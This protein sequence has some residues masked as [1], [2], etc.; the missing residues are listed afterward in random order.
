MDKNAPRSAF[1]SSSLSPASPPAPNGSSSAAAKSGVSGSGSATGAAAQP[2][3]SPEENH[4]HITK[5]QGLRRTTLRTLR[6][7]LCCAIF[8]VFY[9]V[10]WAWFPSHFYRFRYLTVPLVHAE[11]VYITDNQQRKT[12]CRVELLREVADYEVAAGERDQSQSAEMAADDIPLHSRML[13]FRNRRFLLNPEA[14]E[15]ELLRPPATVPQGALLSAAAGAGLSLEDFGARAA[16]Y[17]RNLMCIPIPSIPAVMVAEV[18]SPFFVFQVYSV[19]LWCFE[20][21]WVFAAVI[22]FMA[23]CSL[24]MTVY[25]T[26]SSMVALRELAKS[27]CALTVIRGGRRMLVAST[28]LVIG[29]VAVLSEAIDVPCDLA[30]LTGSVVVNEAM[31]TGESVPVVKTPIVDPAATLSAAAAA[32]AISVGK[33]SRTTLFAGSRIMQIKPPRGSAAMLA[34]I[35]RSAT[36]TSFGLSLPEHLLQSSSGADVAGASGSAGDSMAALTGGLGPSSASLLQEQSPAKKAN[37]RSPL[38][39]A[40]VDADDLMMSGGAGNGRSGSFDPYSYDPPTT[41]PALAAAGAFGGA[42]DFDPAAAAAAAAAARLMTDASSSSSTTVRASSH[43]DDSTAAG[44][45][46]LAYVVHTGFAT[47]KGNMLSS[48]LFPPKS[49]FEFEAQA[50]K[51]LGFLF[52][53]A[54]VGFGLT[55]WRYH[56][57]GSPISVMVLRALDLATIVVPPS[58]PLAMSIGISFSIVSLKAYR[59]FCIAPS[60]INLSGQI[61]LMCFDKTGTLTTDSLRFRGVHAFV[62]LAP[63]TLADA[64]AVE[65]V[66]AAVATALGT[67]PTVA[68]RRALATISTRASA[69]PNAAAT[70]AAAAAAFSPEAGLFSP[71]QQLGAA[72]D[73]LGALPDGLLSPDSTRS[74]EAPADGGNGAVSVFS[75]VPAKLPPVVRAC[76]ATCHSLTIHEGAFIGDPLEIEGFGACQADFADAAAKGVLFHAHLKR[77]SNTA[78]GKK[79]DRIRRRLR[80]EAQLPQLGFGRT[81]SS[82]FGQADHSAHSGGDSYDDGDDDTARRTP[83]RRDGEDAFGDDDDVED[84]YEEP[85]D[86]ADPATGAATEAGS[87]LSALGSTRERSSSSAPFAGGRRHGAA[88]AS[89]ECDCHYYGVPIA[90]DPSAPSIAPALAAEVFCACDC[91]KETV[92]VASAYADS[93]RRRRGAAAASGSS[94]VGLG[95]IRDHSHSHAHGHHHHGGA[96]A[97]LA[98]GQFVKVPTVAAATAL[99]PAPPALTQLTAALTAAGMPPRPA[100]TSLVPD[101]QSLTERK[102]AYVT[103][104]ASASISGKKSSANSSSETSLSSSATS[105]SSSAAA[106]WASGARGAPRGTGAEGRSWSV[107]RQFPFESGLQRMGVLALNEYD[108]TLFSFVKGAPEMVAKL[109][110]PATV[111][112]SYAATV[113]WYTNEGHRVIALAA[114]PVSLGE[115]DPEASFAQQAATQSAGSAA[116][117]D[118]T[119]AAAAAS[120]L[121]D[122]RLDPASDATE[123]L[124]H[125]SRLLHGAAPL[126][127]TADGAV[128]AVTE[129]LAKRDATEVRGFAESGLT[130]LGL[131]VMENALKPATIPTLAALRRAAVRCVMVTGDNVKTAVSISKECGI[132][133]PDAAVFVSQVPKGVARPT[134]RDIRWVHSHSPGISLDPTTFRVVVAPPGLAGGKLPFQRFE[135]AVTGDAYALL[136]ID[137][138]AAIEA[139]A[140]RIDDAQDSGHNHLIPNSLSMGGSHTPPLARNPDGVRPAFAATPA[141]SAVGQGGSPLSPDAN[142]GSAYSGEIPLAGAGE[143][144]G[145]HLGLRDPENY[146]VA[147]AGFE[148]PALRDPHKATL[149]QRVILAGA[150]FSRM[151]PDQKAG[152]VSHYMALGMYTGMCGDGANDCGALKTAHMGVS[153]AES[154]ASIAAPFTSQISDIS[155]IPIVLCQGRSALATA[156]QLFRYMGLY[157]VIQFGSCILLYF[158]GGNF[159]D[160]QFLYQDLFAVFPLALVMG[161]T[162]SAVELTPHRPSSNLLSPLNIFSMLLHMAVALGFQL[163][164]YKLTGRVDGYIVYPNEDYYCELWEATVI[165]YFVS[166][167]YVLFAVVFSIAPP[168]KRAPWHNP[169]LVAVVIAS[170]VCTVTFFFVGPKSFIL[171]QDDMPIPRD[172]KVMVM[173]IFIAHCIVTV[174]IEFGVMRLIRWAASRRL[175]GVRTNTVFGPGDA[176]IESGARPYHYLRRQFEDM[177][178]ASQISIVIPRAAHASSPTSYDRVD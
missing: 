23:L 20:N 39:S 104:A 32:A 8:S 133:A 87:D 40:L 94:D 82:G 103:A 141:A 52:S 89:C 172:W 70:A 159:C 35:P 16:T 66:A 53:L 135:L 1:A 65:T 101:A 83:R 14:G 124:P 63:L 46:V 4:L 34:A 25:D 143:T 93:L 15:F 80:R 30:L 106:E 147:S 136:L 28:D 165:H 97:A 21:Y 105:S 152:L 109:C 36:S 38:V 166:M 86:D 138:I 139:E 33:D 9:A 125:L 76:L 49:Q 26:R 178:P 48:M 59:I 85:D 5:C 62:P 127:P 44:G 161:R 43:A 24:A 6:H 108:M 115:L 67:N 99:R 57:I 148:Y 156:F 71:P 153:L 170:F 176:R 31:L 119:A 92:A 13:V 61:K 60:R 134:A 113:D 75:F 150:V 154:E 37:A 45:A 73:A 167:Q 128:L 79:L 146:V 140:R 102:S 157:S 122:L 126:A 131:V 18:L 144:N 42:A 130:L 158:K 177:W 137:H 175:A 69:A 160:Y 120:P 162:P 78:V 111:P 95:G 163:I 98:R 84:D 7:Y 72:G 2:E 149:L 56:L 55:I 171:M 47:S 58:L 12:L 110:D 107:M 91:A 17:G 88:A 64:R 121:S 10:F 19:I 54:A 96:A 41:S 77:H 174:V 50:Y 90:S 117:A 151:T 129:A 168:W 74:N 114:K 112:A 22:G 3:L 169:G 100:P 164:V 51:F 27:D 123:S 81:A 142:N 11:W 173:L 145:E 68:T 118:I 155:C 29:D 132:I 116:G